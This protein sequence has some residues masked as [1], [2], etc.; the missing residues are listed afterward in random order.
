MGKRKKI[1]LINL[2]ISGIIALFIANFIASGTIAENYTDE[3][4]VAP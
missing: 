4:F 1:A 2:F 3:Q